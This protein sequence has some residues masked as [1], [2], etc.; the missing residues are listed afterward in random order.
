M[1]AFEVRNV[2]I[3]MRK[4]LRDA[5]R[6]RWFVLY[7]IAFALLAL[8]LSF[9]SL[10]GAELV[11]FAAFGRT[12]AGLI[13]LV[14][15][16][17]PLMALTIGAQSISLEAERGTLG[18][19]LAQPVSRAE[20]IVGKF[21]GAALALL[22]A[23]TVGFGSSALFLAPHVAA[24][25]SPGL[26]GWLVGAAFLFSL[27]MLAVG[28]LISVFSTRAGAAT[29][30]AI[31]IWFCLVL[32]GDLGLMGSALIMKVSTPTLLGLAMANPVQ[33]FKIAALLGLNPTLDLLGPAGMYAVSVYG[34]GLAGLLIG[35]LVAWTLAPLVAGG[36][37]FMRKN[38][39]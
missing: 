25:A 24:S 27:A 37:V 14:I 18:L 6:S 7:A 23:L 36:V 8:G 17:V 21:C 28:F 38:V 29:G 11:G 4:E 35:V 15:L 3:V 5:L 26:L 39:R 30:V 19:L 1:R 34:R 13:N 31:F 2:V 10:A 9:L 16:V 33:A 22:G 12:A 20:V 32:F